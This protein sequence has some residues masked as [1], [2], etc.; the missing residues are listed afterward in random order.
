MYNIRFIKSKKLDE[1]VFGGKDWS[2]R[3]K[4]DYSLAVLDKL[5]AGE[6]LKTGIEG[7]GAEVVK[8]SDFDVQKLQELRDKIKN[9][10]PTSPADLNKCLLQIGGRKSVW[11]TLYKGDFSHYEN[12]GIEFEKDYA[13]EFENKY[14]GLLQNA[15]IIDRDDVVVGIDSPGKENNRRP[16]TD[17]NND[18]T[19]ICAPLKQTNPN[20][21]GDIGRTV[22]DIIVRT[23]KNPTGYFLS[24]KYGPKVTFINVGV[25]KIFPK[26]IFESP[27]IE[28]LEFSKWNPR[29]YL[30]SGKS[31]LDL[32]GIDEYRFKMAYAEYIKINGITPPKKDRRIR[33][34]AN[35]DHVLDKI[36]VE[37]LKTF[38]QS[39]IGYGY[40]L[41]HSTK[42]TFHIYDLRNPEN[43]GALLQGSKYT[44]GYD[45]FDPLD[46]F[47][48]YPVNGRSKQVNAVVVYPN[49]ILRFNFRSKKGNVC[50]EELMSD[51]T[52]IGK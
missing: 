11:N 7:T 9:G 31:M 20:D 44:G 5:I 36:D 43:V 27:N 40:I 1:S 45:P 52:I 35:P 41:V 24:L 4:F 28:E 10:E 19:I 50:P 18:G 32:F 21:P 34:Y 47:V 49:M 29:T 42:K 33:S 38:I 14:L 30:P 17:Y 6:E 22:A 51:Y 46:V 15:G 23:A 25:S 3:G 16:L 26:E 48:E 8:G 2:H 13:S 12:K 37:K 39:A